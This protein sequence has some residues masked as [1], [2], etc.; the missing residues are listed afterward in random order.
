MGDSYISGEAGRWLGNS[1]DTSGSR[2][3]TDR[4][5]VNGSYDPTVVYGPTYNSGCDR[6]DT[7]EVNSAPGLAQSTRINIACS[8]ATTANV[9]RAADGGQSFKGEAP[10]A[11]QLA[12]LAATDDVQTIVLSIGG[13]DL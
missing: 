2:D 13:N 8:G 5:Y 7:A 9:L 11:D 3:G 4:A 6:S 10:Q 12:Q 1:D